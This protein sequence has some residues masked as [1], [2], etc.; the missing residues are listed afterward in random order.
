MAN[1]DDG[2]LTGSVKK[3]SSVIGKNPGAFAAHGDGKGFVKIA[4][5][6]SGVV[7]HAGSGGIVAEWGGRVVLRWRGVGGAFD[8]VE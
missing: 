6:E 8:E 4:R 3:S 2:G 7:W 5:K 1:V